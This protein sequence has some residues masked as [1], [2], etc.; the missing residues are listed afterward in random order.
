[1]TKLEKIARAIHSKLDLRDWDTMAG[2][3]CTKAAQ[4]EYLDGA[5]A[6]LEVLRDL[7]IAKTKAQRDAVSEMIAAILEEK[8]E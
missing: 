4:K 3:C 1:M 8:P 6:A 2:P 5:R 7:P